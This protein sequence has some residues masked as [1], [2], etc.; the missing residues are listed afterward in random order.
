[1]TEI[2]LLENYKHAAEKL[3]QHARKYKSSA[4]L[5]QSLTYNTAMEAAIIEEQNDKRHN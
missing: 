3:L 2:E 5:V 4:Y 1:M